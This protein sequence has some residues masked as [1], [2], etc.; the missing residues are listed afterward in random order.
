M[1]KHP[2]VVGLKTSR[3]IARIE[4]WLAAYCDGRWQLKLEQMA[5]DLSH[6]YLVIS[7]E[8]AKDR[9]AFKKA[10]AKAAAAAEDAARAHAEKQAATENT[11]KIAAA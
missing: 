10:F 2:F 1:I 9:A 11:E 3:P 7:F 4:S 6:K 5:E 8:L